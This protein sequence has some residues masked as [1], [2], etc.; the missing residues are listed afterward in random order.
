M[1]P[2]NHLVPGQHARVR[3][4]RPLKK[5]SSAFSSPT[6]PT[7]IGRHVGETRLAAEV[8]LRR[9]DSWSPTGSA[10]RPSLTGS[11]FRKSRCH[12]VPYRVMWSLAAAWQ[13]KRRCAPLG[14]RG[15]QAKAPPAIITERMAYR[16]RPYFY[17]A[18]SLNGVTGR[19]PPW[20]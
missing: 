20:S 19:Y 8:E 17:L 12:A 3:R 15:V 9:C 13:R 11:S 18:P 1:Q 7:R 10:H 4:S 2:C 6:R 16:M 14:R 5:L